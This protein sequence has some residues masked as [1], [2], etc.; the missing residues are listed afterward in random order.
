M[1]TGSF[2]RN[3]SKL[4]YELDNTSNLRSNL[5][6]YQILQNSAE[7]QQFLGIEKIVWFS[8]QFYMACVKNGGLYRL[9]WT[10][11]TK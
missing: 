10:W 2:V 7:K 1:K 9:Q 8:L 5:P 3:L 11:Y 4:G 6:Q